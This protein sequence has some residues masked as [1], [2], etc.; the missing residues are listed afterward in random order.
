M[1]QNELTEI[2]LQRSYPVVKA[3]EIIQ[4]ARYDLSITELKLLA[5]VFSKIKP[6]DAQLQEYSFSVKEFCQVC[7]IDFESGKNYQRV[8]ATLKGLRDKSFWV[9]DE[10]GCEVT[11]GWLQKARINKGSGR[12][13]VKLDEDMQKYVLGL[14][15][16]YTQYELLS[17]LP[18]KS[19]Y[20][21]RIYEL[22]KSYSF[23]G[24]H[25]FEIDDLKKQLYA[26]HYLNFKDFRRK[27]IEIAVK[28]INTYTDLETSWEPVK[29]GNKVTQV[30]FH[31]KQR[32][33][34]GRY[35]AA[36]RANDQIEGQMSIFDYYDNPVDANRRP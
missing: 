34:W 10:N 13:T 24:A 7:G 5:F 35:K 1:E 14:F 26:E 8:K 9:T 16:N 25:T 33:T 11:V 12:I 20:S 2:R 18:M 19:A 28:E 17:T 22:L 36:E 23:T 4:K 21:F 6:T 3:N 15:S 32:D 30:T 27:V 31:I 29:F